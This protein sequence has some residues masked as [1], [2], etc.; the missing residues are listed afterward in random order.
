[1]PCRRPLP[2]NQAPRKE[3]LSPTGNFRTAADLFAVLG[4]PAEGFLPWRSRMDPFRLG[5]VPSQ[6]HRIEKVANVGIARRRRSAVAEESAPKTIMTP[7]LTWSQSVH[8]DNRCPTAPA[9]HICPHQIR[10]TRPDLCPP[11]SLRNAPLSCTDTVTL[12]RAIFVFVGFP[13]VV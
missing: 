4:S 5:P 6:A 10:N 13:S 11:P 12:V 2:S 7:L 3:A 1:M 8:L 9:A